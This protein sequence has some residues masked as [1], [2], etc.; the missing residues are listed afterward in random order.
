LKQPVLFEPPTL[1]A[2]TFTSP[3]VNEKNKMKDEKTEIYPDRKIKHET[4]TQ[5]LQ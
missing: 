2:K 4:I 5:K 1:Y 3:P